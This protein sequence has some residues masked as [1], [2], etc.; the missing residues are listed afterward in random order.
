MRVHLS[1][2]IYLLSTIGLAQTDSGK[3]A[4][5]ITT[6]QIE[7]G[8]VA[9]LHLASG[10]ATSV[11]VPEEISSVV[12][13]N[14]ANFKAE[15]AE[16]EPRLVFLK[17]VTALPCESNALITTKS[18]KQISLYLVSSGK[19]RPNTR[20][21]FF[22]E[23]RGQESIGISADRQS[24]LIPETHSVSEPSVDPHRTPAHEQD[25]VAKELEKQKGLS[26][27]L[28]QGT[29]MLAAIGSSIQHE[30]QTILGFSI[31]N[32]S[33]RVIELLP[34]QLEL[35]GAGRRSGVKQI[36]AEPVPFSEYRMSRRT[37]EPGQR[38]DG[39]VVFERLSK[40][41]RKNCCCS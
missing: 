19:A 17:P 24:F 31:L 39:V 34:P 5:G 29:E 14:P 13:G 20:V 41:P 2:T 30:S 3:I 8:T 21:D 18:G 7:P 27:P 16:A 26:A 35:S 33:K 6:I 40:R 11:K 36:I 4:P 28:W 12:I 37:L 1:F 25:F 10:Y 23:Y 22:V 9:V 32:S 38:A 15:D